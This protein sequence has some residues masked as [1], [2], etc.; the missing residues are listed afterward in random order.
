MLSYE[1]FSIIS[2]IIYGD[3]L[4][5]K[6]FNTSPS[7]CIIQYKIALFFFYPVCIFPAILVFYQ[8]YA[9]SKDSL[10]VENS[11]FWYS[12]ICT[13]SGSFIYAV[14]NAF[15]SRNE[16]NW[17]TMATRLYCQ[18]WNVKEKW[19]VFYVYVIIVGSLS[20]IS[21]CFAGTYKFFI[22]IT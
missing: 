8:W 17:G 16:K 7:I 6:A 2:L 22:I 13:W 19:Y 3:D 5:D 21:L 14:V 12:I 18:A 4:I 11:C 1:L 10:N 20:F 9:I 15:L